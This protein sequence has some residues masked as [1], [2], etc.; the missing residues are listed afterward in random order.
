MTAVDHAH[1]AGLIAA[2]HPDLDPELI[3]RYVAALAEHCTPRDCLR[4]VPELISIGVNPHAL[5]GALGAVSAQDAQ[6]Q[7]Y[8]GQ[9]P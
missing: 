1:A 7:I 2:D 9:L 5:A 6:H 4:Y 3:G 8:L